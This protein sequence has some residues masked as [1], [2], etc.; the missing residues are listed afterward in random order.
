MRASLVGHGELGA[1]VLSD[2]DE[3][4]GL[5]PEATHAVL[6]V[7]LERA[8]AEAATPDARAHSM[9]LSELLQIHGDAERSREVLAS[10]AAGHPSDLDVHRRLLA[11][12]TAAGRWEDVLVHCARLVDADEGP[13]QVDAVLAWAKAAENAGRPGDALAGLERVH[14]EHPGEA[15]VR[16][17]LRAAYSASG[18]HLALAEVWLSD[19]ASATSDDAR[20]EALRRAGELFVGPAGDPRRAVEALR[21]ALS[22]REDDADTIVLLTD[23]WIAAAGFTE[24]VELLQT[25]IASPRRRRSPALAAMQFRM[26]R[27]AGLSG[28]QDTQLEWLKVALE[29]DK[30]HGGIAAALAELAM[31]LHDDV[32]AM[33]ALKVVT[34]QKT[35]GPMS[36][37]TAFLR[38]AQLA[39]RGG[40][41]QK[42]LLWARRARI[43]E[44]D[45][46]EAEEFL[47]S[48][49]E[50]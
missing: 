13:A 4:Y 45:F 36:K 19:A 22:L 44:G 38:Q 18:S 47:R 8:S 28:D 11:A 31:A 43:E 2:L 1:S 26:A 29:T 37:G 25:A 40:D 17:A 27:I 3:A 5:D 24:A 41:T 35:P 15:R 49:G 9:R 21:A 46:K 14:R 33:N 7:A 30:T 34:L 48:L 20:F 10:W 6:A 50:G 16:D 42:A 39:Q 12:D 23:A 32:T